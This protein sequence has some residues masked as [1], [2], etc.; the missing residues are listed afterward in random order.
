MG[1]WDPL[2]NV[3]GKVLEFFSNLFG[4]KVRDQRKRDEHQRALADAHARE[5]R[6]LYLDVAKRFGKE[7][8]FA[9]ENAYVTGGFENTWL[10][11]YSSKQ[12]RLMSAVD[13]ISDTD[14]RQSLNAILIG[15]QYRHPLEFNSMQDMV[16]Q[17]MLLGQ[18]IALT[19]A[20]GEP[21]LTDGNVQL[22]LRIHKVIRFETGMD[23]REANELH[24]QVTEGLAKL[25]AMIN[26]YNKGRDA[27]AAIIGDDAADEATGRRSP[28]PDPESLAPER[29]RRR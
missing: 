4:I 6:E 11:R 10:D 22:L 18:R 20:R 24:A 29:H 14:I 9:R 21:A 25:E 23:I 26:E 5:V 17:G 16:F 28:P 12:I 19:A 7:A 8:E 15:C 27:M 3:V 1:P 2:V 13:L